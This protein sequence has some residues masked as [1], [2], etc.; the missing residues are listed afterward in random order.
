V[1]PQADS[2]RLVATIANDE[3]AYLSDW[4]RLNA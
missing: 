2:P 3:I 4:K 1:G